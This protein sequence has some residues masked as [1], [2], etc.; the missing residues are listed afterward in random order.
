MWNA[1]QTVAV[2]NPNAAGGR[3]GKQWEDLEREL[4]IRLGSVQ[5]V[6]T[7]RAGHAIELARS[8]VESGATTILSMGG[9]G[10]HNE[11]VN[12]IMLAGPAP[13]TINL[14]LLPAGTGGDFRRMCNHNADALTAAAALPGAEGLPIDVGSL[15]FCADNGSETDR[16]FINIASFG[17]GGLVDRFAN[18]SKK[19]LGGKATFYIATV[20]ALMTYK[21]ATVRLRIDDR[22]MGEHTIT[23]IL[24]CNGRY[25]GGGM[26]FA[27]DAKLGDGL[28]DVIILRHKSIL[29]TIAMTGSI[30]T[31]KH[32]ENPTVDVHQGARVTA[33]TITDAAAY[34]DI[35][36][37]APGVL[38]ANFRIHH[39]AVNLLDVRP[40]VV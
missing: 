5:F 27:P 22:D 4:R 34:L 28:F 37:E 40:E 29:S 13:G 8:A 1:D 21:P 38:P 12:G 26:K 15:S 35:D 17:I 18:Q 23:N 9:D 2:V 7:E 36:G 24:V 39:H 6:L 32:I 11:V 10:T 33:E 31:G 3:V 25:C 20:K 19:R 14:G 16:Y 30:Y